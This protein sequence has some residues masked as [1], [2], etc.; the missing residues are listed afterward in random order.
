MQIY[1]FSYN[2]GRYLRNALESIERH[3]PPCRVTV[4]DDASDD[5]EVFAALDAY[6]HMVGVVSSASDSSG[7][8]GG[9]YRNMQQAV[10]LTE[11][12]PVV[13]FLQDDMQ[14][15]RDI[16][17]SDIQHWNR[18]FERHAS[19]FQ[20]YG[21]FV[22]KKQAE[23][24]AHRLDIDRD[25]PAYFRSPDSGR[26]SYFSAVGV[27]HVGRMQSI[28]WKF[29]PSEGE[30][31]R[32]VREMGWYMGMTPWPFMMWL[33]NAESAKFRRRGFLHWLAETWVRAGYHPYRPM[34]VAAARWLHERPLE[35]LPVAE[36][37]LEPEGMNTDREWLFADA[38]K[39]IK[40][41]HRHLKRRKKKRVRQE[42]SDRGE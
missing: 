16:D 22:K 19:S 3:V 20:F 31:N 15:V 11:D 23:G 35:E 25:V 39:A 4:M 30:N 37:L 27:F 2:R 9:L 40:P 18:Y 5:P 21:C 36:Y 13:L 33:P 42:Q 26:R 1:V 8:L 7:Y 12:D 10:A 24:K 34:D 17:A 41:L 14:I 6:A 38:T 29:E 32:K 28:G